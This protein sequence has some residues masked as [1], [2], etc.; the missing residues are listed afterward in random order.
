MDR[1]RSIVVF[2][3]LLAAMP[4]VAVTP[5][6][7]YTTYLL[8]DT[9]AGPA[10]VT[11]QS[12][13]YGTAH[14]DFTY[15]DQPSYRV[16]G[17]D[18][19]QIEDV[20]GQLAGEM[21]VAVP[22]SAG[23]FGLVEVRPGANY[24][25]AES[26]RPY[27]IVATEHAPMNCVGGF[28]RLYFFVPRGHTGGS[29]YLH[30]FSVG[31]AGRVVVHDPDGNVAVEVEDDFNEPAAVSFTVPEGMDG[32][33]W[34]LGLLKPERDDWDV[35][36][37]ALWLSPSLSGLLFTNP[38]WAERLSAPFATSWTPVLDFEGDSPVQT[39]QWSQKVADGQP[40]PT[41]DVAVSGE[42]PH[43][44]A[45]SLRVEMDLPENVA[46]QELKLFTVPLPIEKVE[47]VCLWLYGDGSG[48]KLMLRVRDSSLEHHY[49]AAGTIDWVG[50]GELVGDF[51]HPSDI[52]G[53]DENKRIDGPTVSVVLQIGHAA[54]QPVHS[55]YYVDDLGVSP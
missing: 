26:D 41:W 27:G 8:V 48:R 44:G 39:I 5:V 35:D 3:M 15:G 2:T 20:D 6:L 22:A 50:W 25:L 40:Q 53:G 55:V 23:D 9:T 12:R 37:C 47:K 45:Q 46:R 33:T 16:I 32:R 14:G 21:D 36:D 51:T 28:E 31:E 10:T 19:R 24:A 42:N 11:M 7:R 29:V 52:A 34:S 43:S 4:A 18:G 13:S 49:Y 1:V 38:D 30:A 54:G 17:A